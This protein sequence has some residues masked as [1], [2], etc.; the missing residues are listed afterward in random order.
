MEPDDLAIGPR[1]LGAGVA[2][3]SQRIYQDFAA[4]AWNSHRLDLSYAVR[5]GAVTPHK[6]DGG[7]QCAHWGTAEAASDTAVL[8]DGWSV[9]LG[10]RN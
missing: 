5:P 3:F 2:T 10:S 4:L 7:D 1:I 9:H 6:L 8:Y